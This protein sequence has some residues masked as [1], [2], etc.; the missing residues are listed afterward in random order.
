VDGLATQSIVSASVIENALHIVS[1]AFR[2]AMRFGLLPANPAQG[3]KP[4][5]RERKQML[6]WTSTEARA[7]LQDPKA[8]IQARAI[9]RLALTTGLRPG[10]LRALQWSEVDLAR[11]IVH[12]RRSMT[13]DEQFRAAMGTDTKTLGSRRSVSLSASTVASLRA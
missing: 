1:G 5:P 10:E 6:T 8:S 7:V 12:I 9:Y 11:G 3:V 4:P 2:E 13:R